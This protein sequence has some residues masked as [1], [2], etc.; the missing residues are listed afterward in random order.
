MNWKT[1]QEDWQ[2][3][4]E[5]SASAKIPSAS[6]L[7][8]TREKM[9]FFEYDNGQQ[10]ALIGSIC[11]GLLGIMA[12]MAFYLEPQKMMLLFIGGILSLSAFLQGIR[13]YFFRKW[14]QPQQDLKTYY[15]YALKKVRLARR[16]NWTIGAGLIC[17]TGFVL[18]I[19]KD[20]FSSIFDPTVDARVLVVLFPFLLI[21]GLLVWYYRT[22]HP[23]QIPELEKELEK[24]V[25]DF[26]SD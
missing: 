20:Q 14:T 2:N 9:R 6:Q 19:A 1:L 23:Y 16:T 4:A 21:V 24:I 13:F 7:N 3:S 22:Q 15:S 5:V 11:L 12:F 10:S 26:E 8:A 17:W 25:A 18:W